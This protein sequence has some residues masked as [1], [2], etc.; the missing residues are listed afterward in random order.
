MKNL[1]VAVIGAGVGGLA[2]AARL[3][4]QGLDVEVFERSDEP[5]GR[6]GRLGSKGFT[7]DLGPTL[8]L[9]PEVLKG[10][11]EAVGRRAEDYLELVRCDPNYQVHFRDGSN[12]TFTTDLVKMGEELERFEPGSFEQ[13]L[14]FLSMG[15]R[16]YQTSLDRFVGRNFDSVASFFSPKNLAHV[17]G[18]RAHKKMYAEVSRY[19]R[20]ERLRAALTF[21][22]MYLGISPFDSPAVYGLLPFTELAMGIWFPKGGMHA[23]PRALERVGRELGARYH[24]R[25]PVSR[26]DVDPS[27]R[28]CRGVWLEDG[29]R[30]EADL[31]VCNAD[32]PW[33]YEHLVAPEV[34]RLPAASRLK[35]TSSAYMMYLGTG[36]RY[37]GLLHHNVVLGRGYRQSFSDIFEKFRVPE[38]PSFYVNAPAHTDPSL[39]PTGKDSLYFLVPVPRQH[40][41]LDWAV[42]G[43]KVRARV[44]ERMAELGY[45]QLE[46]DIEFEH[47]LTPDDWAQQLNLKHGAAFGLS[48]HFFQVGPFRPANVD[49]KVKNLFFVGASTQPGT[50]VPMVMLSAKLV[51]ERVMAYAERQAPRSVAVPP[52]SISEAA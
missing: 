20:D 44:F 47:T 22:T 37:D 21:Q 51:A 43:P 12:L 24:Y 31:V 7:F 42:E 39:A 50:G 25:A 10:T 15:R 27:T 45:P 18:I 48:H 2:A 30:V 1:K 41:S 4:H 29:S 46:A 17:I 11:F 9:M 14:A 34:T 52:M 35:Y 32:L 38:D 23:I 36:R 49:P 26:I 3:A 16:Q 8:L 5:G 6:A 28:L 40:P 33:A 13:Y 19:F